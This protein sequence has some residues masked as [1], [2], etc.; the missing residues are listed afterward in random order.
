VAARIQ[1]P[2]RQD[3]YEVKR[4][5]E[6]EE[7]F[8]HGLIFN[9]KDSEQLPRMLKLLGWVEEATGNP[10]HPRYAIQNQIICELWLQAINQDSA[11]P[12]SLLCLHHLVPHQDFEQGFL[13]QHHHAGTKSG[14]RGLPLP[15]KNRIFVQSKICTPVVADLLAK[16]P[17]YR[18]RFIQSLSKNEPYYIMI[19]LAILY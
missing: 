2:S 16:I 19:G 12:L 1:P 3:Y 14:T 11:A 6:W 7:F 9:K 13:K 18:D 10:Q 17:E 4:T 15:Y 8:L 5:Q